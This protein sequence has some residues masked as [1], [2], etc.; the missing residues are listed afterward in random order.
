M[1]APAELSQLLSYQPLDREH[2][3][4]ISLLTTIQDRYHYLPHNALVL[5]SE[6]LE[7][8]LSQ[9]YS[10]ATFYRAFSLKPRE[11]SPVIDTPEACYI[12]LVEEAKP[13]HV[14]TLGEVRDQIEKTLLDEERNRLEK[15]WIEKLRKK[16]FVRYF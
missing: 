2:I 15:Q 14:K 10:I 5:L 11:L 3:A 13:A 7:I 8:P 16:T 1:I 4:L 6:S 9:I 12:L